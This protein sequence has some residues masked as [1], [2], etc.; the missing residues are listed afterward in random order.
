M[1]SLFLLLLLGM[2]SGC[3]SFLQ[4]EYPP[5]QPKNNPARIL[6]IDVIGRD[7]VGQSCAQQAHKN[8]FAAPFILG[9]AA[10]TEK[11]CSITL[12]Q[13]TLAVVVGHELRHCF[14]GN[15]HD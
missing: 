2:L 15:F 11:T 4:N 3:T 8:S 12:P 5:F 14:E 9:C 7:D 10:W 6:A 1:K 13:N